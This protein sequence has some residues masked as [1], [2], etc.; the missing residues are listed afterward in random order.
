MLCVSLCLLSDCVVAQKVRPKNILVFFCLVL[1][2]LFVLTIDWHKI[3]T[4]IDFSSGKILD[5]DYSQPISW[6]QVLIIRKLHTSKS[7]I[8]KMKQSRSR[9]AI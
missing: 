3:G 4:L 7:G 6:K 9:Q 5:C 2:L 8:W 1:S